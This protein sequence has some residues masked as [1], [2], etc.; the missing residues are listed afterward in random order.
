MAKTVGLA[1]VLL[2]ALVLP[3]AAHDYTAAIG[4]SLSGTKQSAAINLDDCTGAGTPYDCCTGVDTGRCP[5]QTVRCLASGEEAWLE[6]RFPAWVDGSQTVSG[7]IS[8]MTCAAAGCSSG[9]GTAGSQTGCLSVSQFVCIDGDACQELDPGELVG[10]TL[11]EDGT[12]AGIRIT[13]SIPAFTYDKSGNDG[14]LCGADDC[15][16]GTIRYRYARE[17]SGACSTDDLTELVCLIDQ[18]LVE[19]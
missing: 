1:V 13:D 2:V 6:R 3:A 16:D 10:L 18:K 5:T 19:P 15:D 4:G 11:A 8:W 14:T 12:T 17:T 9:Y 7:E